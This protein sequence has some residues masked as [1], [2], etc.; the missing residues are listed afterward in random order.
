MN[1]I[2]E[3]KTVKGVYMGDHLVTGVVTLSRV[4]YGGKVQHTVAL[5]E[6]LNLFGTTRDSVCLDFE[7]IVEICD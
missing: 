7:E 5:K 6:S 2:L 3:G 4:K 1:W